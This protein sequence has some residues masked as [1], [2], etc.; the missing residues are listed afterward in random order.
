MVY[1][2]DALGQ[3]TFGK[4]YW[5]DATPVPGQQFEF[6]FDDIG[7]RT[8]T[9]AGGD[10]SGAGL[11][12]ASY[13]ANSLNQYTNR[14]VSNAF[15]M[16]GIATTSSSV[17]VNSSSADYRRAE[18]FQELVT[19]NNSSTSVWQN[20][21]VTTSG[22]GTNSGNVFV[23]TATETYGYDADG[24]MTN[25]GRW[26]FT[27]DAENRLVNMTSLSTGPS[28]SKRKI[29]FIYDH[30]GRRIQKSVSTWNCSAYVPQS[31][32]RFVYDGWNLVAELNGTNGVIRT[33]VW[34]L[35]LSGS[36]QGAGGVGGLL[37]IKPSTGN[38]SFAAYDG[39]GNVIGLIDAT[40]GATSGNF[41]YGPSGEPIRITPNANNQSPFRFSTKY[42]DDES[43]FLYYGYRYYNPNV[44]RWLSRDPLDEFGGENL[45]NFSA[46]NAV[47]LVE[48]L[49]LDTLEF[50]SIGRIHY[51]SPG[52]YTVGITG[53]VD[54]DWSQSDVS[55]SA[56]AYFYQS[57]VEIKGCD[58]GV[59]NSGGDNKSN[60]SSFVKAWVKN[61]S[62]CRILADCECNVHWFVS[63]FSPGNSGR[64]GA[65]VYGT[66][67]GSFFS[68]Y[69]P[70]RIQSDGSSL[71]W[72]IGDYTKRKIISV[73]PGAT[74]QLYYGSDVNN[75]SPPNMPGAGFTES[76]SG[77]C[78]C[79]V[80]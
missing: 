76:M 18:Y 23:P 51:N 80:L 5:A 56:S 4:K 45:Y 41:E 61:V 68:K 59:C 67:L 34:G 19:V 16:L 60:S 12:P 64:R 32:N 50:W 46:N 77:D 24:N 52:E 14:T 40:T 57:V 36:I 62:P 70:S 49:G 55:R 72:G 48:Y 47:N 20:V 58:Y 26:N 39:N 11:R 8:S 9:K 30:W 43:D 74:E 28:N 37:T 22:G 73:A 78:S 33:Y 1:Q 54:R 15:D 42:T 10:Q 35:D 38:P 69:Y 31:T 21:S 79:T 7:N 53:Q 25:D 6:G 29:D 65:L 66:V 2:Y 71:A 44:G 3:V 27:W 63:N 17:T 75:A 13:S